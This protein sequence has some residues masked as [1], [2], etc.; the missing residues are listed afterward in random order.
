MKKNIYTN[1]EIYYIYILYTAMVCYG[2]LWYAMTH[3]KQ[4]L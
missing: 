1:V 2:K 4:K 3:E